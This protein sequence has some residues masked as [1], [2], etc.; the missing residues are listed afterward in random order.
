MA[1]FH[2]GGAHCDPPV[3]KLIAGYNPWE[4]DRKAAELLGL[5]WR[6]IGHIAAGFK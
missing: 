1:E 5:D 4:V 2:L 3:N 6:R